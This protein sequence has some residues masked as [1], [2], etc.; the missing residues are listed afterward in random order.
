MA[1]KYLLKVLATLDEA[2]ARWFLAR[3]AVAL[4]RGGIQEMHALTGISRPTITKGIRELHEKK[5]LAVSERIRSPGGGRKRLEHHDPQLTM[6][7]E[8]II[9][10]NTAGDPM[11]QL[12]W[13]NKSTERIAEQLNRMGHA[14]SGQTV[15]R[16]LRAAGLLTAVERQESRRG[17]ST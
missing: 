2:Q 6:A 14:V 1:D 9:N 5:N 8:E 13:T 10:E 17:L 11:N 15:G 7:L 4:G 12:R 3:E 16:R